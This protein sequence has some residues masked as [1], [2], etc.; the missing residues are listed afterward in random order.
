MPDEQPD[1]SEDRQE[2]VERLKQVA[3]TNAETIR[4]LE[5]RGVA[6]RPDAV[7]RY[8]QELIID[9]LFGDFNPDDLDTVGTPRIIFEMTWAERLR[10]VLGQMLVETAGQ[11]GIEVPS[12]GLIVPTAN[13]R[14]QN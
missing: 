13:K 3:K 10:K 1:E 4:T 6:L 9:L 2:A 12:S 7:L 14:K 8:R 11:T 5:G